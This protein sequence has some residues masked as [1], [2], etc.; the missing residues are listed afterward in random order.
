MEE[1]KFENQNLNNDLFQ[2]Y[3]DSLPE[4]KDSVIRGE[5][6]DEEANPSA[7]Q[8]QDNSSSGL[9]DQVEKDLLD[10]KR[11]GFGEHTV[12]RNTSSRRRTSKNRNAAAAV[13]VATA[14]GVIAI[15]SLTTFM[16]ARNT[17]SDSYTYTEPYTE[18]E[19]VDPYEEEM[20]KMSGSLSQP[21]IFLNGKYVA[22]PLSMNEF[23][24]EGWKVRTS[25]FSETADTVGSEP[26]S[27]HVE[28]EWGEEIC[29]VS[30]VSPTG[31]PV[32]V[33]EA[34]I[35]GLYTD[36]ESYWYELNGG[37]YVGSSSW[38]VENALNEQGIEW[39]KH[40]N[41]AGTRYVVESAVENEYGYDDYVLRLE[42][43]DD[44]VERITMQLSQ[45]GQ[46]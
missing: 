1:K 19:Y 18:E 14:A 26:V 27:F 37:I 24:Q 7:H 46:Q 16:I 6:P 36:S 20:A 40:G 31:E 12:R 29:E 10:Y 34:I 13:L 8:A 42:L 39:T 44:Y 33:S 3:I 45:S 43:Q 30:V 9:S 23:M 2:E 4:E 21:E 41:D 11:R 38:T 5:V 28:T 17:Y 25:A 15:A 35:T 22:L 32:P